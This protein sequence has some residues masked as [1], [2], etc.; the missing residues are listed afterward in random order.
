M[1]QFSGSPSYTLWWK[2][3]GNMP[4][5]ECRVLAARVEALLAEGASCAGELETA[6]SKTLRPADVREI[7]RLSSAV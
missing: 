4:I 5:S 6:L 1:N 2:L 3:P 7:V